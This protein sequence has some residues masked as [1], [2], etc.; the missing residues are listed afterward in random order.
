M[1]PELADVEARLAR[2]RPVPAAGFRGAL[3]RQLA[4][5]DPG[6]GPRPERLRVR[7]IAWMLGGEMLLALAL[8][9]ALGKL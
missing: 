6:Y 4:E 1:N 2:E 8:L 9:G 7:V 3:G 5:S